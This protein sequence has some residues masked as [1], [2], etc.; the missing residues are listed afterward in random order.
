MSAAL[1]SAAGTFT[2]TSPSPFDGLLRASGRAVL[3]TGATPAGRELLLL[4][5]FLAIVTKR[6][7]VPR[8][9]AHASV[10]ALP[11]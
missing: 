9:V 3:R 7:K 6:F 1:V 5:L 10:L 2:C 8:D 11:D 4:Y